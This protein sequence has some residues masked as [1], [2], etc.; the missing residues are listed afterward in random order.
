MYDSRDKRENCVNNF[1]LNNANKYLFIFFVN[2]KMNKR[3]QKNKQ[4][5]RINSIASDDLK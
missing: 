4:K 2:G 1:K 5:N 3:N